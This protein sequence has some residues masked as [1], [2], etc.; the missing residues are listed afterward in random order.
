MN[1]KT[2][3]LRLRS[4]MILSSEPKSKFKVFKSQT[5]DIGFSILKEKT[6]R[7]VN[8]P[9]RNSGKIERNLENIIRYIP[10]NKFQHLTRGVSQICIVHLQAMPNHIYLVEFK[11]RFLSR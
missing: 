4:F 9:S 5:L 3:D 8:F 10:S 6:K 11:E 2:L 1:N 7:M